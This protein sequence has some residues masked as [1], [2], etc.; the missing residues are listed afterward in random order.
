[1]GIIVSQDEQVAFEEGKTAHNA[2]YA[3]GSNPHRGTAGPKCRAW[4]MGWT[5]AKKEARNA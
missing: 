2:R 5:A 4:N 1:M 3:K